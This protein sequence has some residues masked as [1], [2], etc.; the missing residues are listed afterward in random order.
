MMQSRNPDEIVQ[1]IYRNMPASVT[2]RR[3]RPI[4]DQ[5]TFSEKRRGSPPTVVVRRHLVGAG[6]QR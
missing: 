5:L 4:A 3:L 1:Y 2:D 6:A